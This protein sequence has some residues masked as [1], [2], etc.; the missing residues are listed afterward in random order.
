MKSSLL[1]GH[2]TV[3]PGTGLP[4]MPPWPPPSIQGEGE[5]LNLHVLRV[6]SKGAA[7]SQHSKARSIHAQ[8]LVQQAAYPTKSKES[9]GL[10]LRGGPTLRLA[11]RGGRRGGEGAEGRC[12]SW[13]SG[14]SEDGLQLEEGGMSDFLTARRPPWGRPCW[15]GQSNQIQ[16][17]DPSPSP[18]DSGSSAARRSCSSSNYQQKARSVH[19]CSLREECARQDVMGR[20]R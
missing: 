15:L 17:R 1:S 6:A 10:L 13:S 5:P 18:E 19:L 3:G 7:L 11:R 9:R 14:C 8:S 20:F 16:W 2:Q 4:L 12:A